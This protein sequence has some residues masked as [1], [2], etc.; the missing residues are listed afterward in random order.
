MRNRVR[1]VTVLFLTVFALHSWRVIH[2][3]QAPPE[4]QP[5]LRGYQKAPQPISD[6]LSARPTPLVQVSPSGK[7]LLADDRLANPPISDLAQPMLRLAGLRIN[8]AT[9]GRH[10]PPRFVRLRLYYA[11]GND[12]A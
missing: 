8:P 7:W 11:L 9:N 5:V 2:A 10:H 6:I 12:Q 1:H 4:E 3:Q